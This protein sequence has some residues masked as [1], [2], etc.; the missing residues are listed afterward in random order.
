MYAR[1]VPNVLALCQPDHGMRIELF[2]AGTV[3]QPPPPEQFCRH[4]DAFSGINSNRIL[5]LFMGVLEQ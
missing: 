1:D 3:Q 2:N 5:C 4:R